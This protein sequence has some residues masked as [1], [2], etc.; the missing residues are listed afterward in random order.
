MEQ[1][2]CIGDVLWIVSTLSSPVPASLHLAALPL[3]PSWACP[4]WERRSVRSSHTHPPF[5]VQSRWRDGDGRGGSLI[6]RGV[7]PT[8][9][10]GPFCRTAGAQYTTQPR[11][12]NPLT[13]MIRIKMIN[14]S[15]WKECSR[16][17]KQ[18][19]GWIFGQGGTIPGYY[20]H[21]EIQSS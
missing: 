5:L 7:L 12:T 6:G 1:H 20:I 11:H 17:R 16:D 21:R 13:A 3:K 10:F 18:P 9:P 8:P 19:R 4:V 14:V 2:I 15:G